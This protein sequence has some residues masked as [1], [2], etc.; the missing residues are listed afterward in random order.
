MID[1]LKVKQLFLDLI[2]YHNFM[3]NNVEFRSDV[4]VG[5]SQN[6]I[7]H[8]LCCAEDAGYITE[9]ELDLLEALIIT[10]I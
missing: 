4:M 7:G 9:K 6:S 3:V 5:M 2:T 1:K 8:L 10:H